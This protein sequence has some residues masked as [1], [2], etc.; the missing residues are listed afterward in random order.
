MEIRYQILIGK[1]K[2]EGPHERP[3]IIS[4]RSVIP[5]LA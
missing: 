3:E 1:P 2:G 5:H 4:V